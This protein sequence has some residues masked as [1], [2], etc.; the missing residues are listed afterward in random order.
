MF[1]P[2][3]LT[4]FVRN[5][6]AHADERRQRLQSDC[7]CQPN[8][9]AFASCYI[10]DYRGSHRCEASICYHLQNVFHHFGS[11]ASKAC[12]RACLQALEVA[13][14]PPSGSPHSCFSPPLIRPTPSLR[15]KFGHVQIM[16]P[17]TR[18]PRN[19]ENC[20]SEMSRG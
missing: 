17:T 8:I 13:W 11:V 10:P 5:Q 3:R 20:S 18:W 12:V 4:P 15:F 14:P 7:A 2:P 16:D 1:F 6:M 9:G 19:L